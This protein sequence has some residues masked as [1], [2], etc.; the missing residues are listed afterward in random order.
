MLGG[1][2]RRLAAIATAVGAVA[3]VAGCGGASDDGSP[4]FDAATTG[5]TRVEPADRQAAPVI[6]G[7]DLDGN[8]LS[9]ADFA[10][11]TIVVNVWGSWCGPC[12][13]EAPAFAQVS[14]KY[15]DR[16]VEFLGVNVRDNDAAAKSFDKKFG[17]DYRSLS[18]Q[19][20]K[21]LL[22]FNKTLPSQAV[23]TTWIIDADGKVAVR[24]LVD[25]LTATTLSGL[26]DDVQKSTA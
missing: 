7:D 3:L 17:I 25:G 6:E 12:R 18:D 13:K 15:A 5:I 24:A 10:G 2:R 11:K 8:P 26:I 22:G 4:N 23:P 9:S 19:G 20:G 1:R 16:G 14:K 21:S